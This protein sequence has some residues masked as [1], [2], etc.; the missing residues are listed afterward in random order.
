M[1]KRYLRSGRCR[2][3][4]R[5]P[6]TAQE[7]R[8]TPTGFKWSRAGRN[9]KNL[10]TE[11]DDII[12]RLEK[13]WKRKRK[14]QYRESPRGQ[15]HEVY[16]SVDPYRWGRRHYQDLYKITEYLQD[17]DIPYRQEEDNEV[18]YIVNAIATGQW[19]LIVVPKVVIGDD[20]K[21]V[22]DEDGNSKIKWVYDHEWIPFKKPKYY[23]RKRSIFKGYRVIYWTNK[24]IQ[25]PGDYT[26]D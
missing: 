25:L 15:R 24:N 7:R 4:W 9:Q 11:R 23:Y 17:H 5:H 2:R 21:A 22:K 18:N 10:P 20:N 8:A 16:I 26:C 14:T 1:Y 12:V 19:K 13:S 3:Y 6:R